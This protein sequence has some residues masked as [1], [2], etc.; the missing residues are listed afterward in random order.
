MF[1]ENTEALNETIDFTGK[2]GL[3]LFANMHPVIVASP[4]NY[5]NLRLPSNPTF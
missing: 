3:Y 2:E 5:I 4:R 1:T